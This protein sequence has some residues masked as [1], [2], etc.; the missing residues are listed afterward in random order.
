MAVEM[1]TKVEMAMIINMMF[2]LLFGL[3]LWS[4]VFGFFVFASS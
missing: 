2:L 1:Q 3:G 4:L